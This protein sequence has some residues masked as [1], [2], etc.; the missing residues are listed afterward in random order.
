M[1]YREVH[2]AACRV[3]VKGLKNLGLMK[4]DVDEAVAKGAH[5]LFMPHG[6]GHMMGMDVHDMEDIGERL[7][8]YDNETPRGTDIGTSALR[9]GRKLQAGMVMTVEPGIYFIPALIEK[10]RKEG[11]CAEFMNYAAIEKYVSFGGI[12]IED[13]LLITPEG[14]RMLGDRRIPVTVAEIEEYMAAQ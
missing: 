4:G 1:L 10:W 6:L 14:N 12:R 5:S 9:M 3:I 8:G 7:V 13:D 2:L 11:L